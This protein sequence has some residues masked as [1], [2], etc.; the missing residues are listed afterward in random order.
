MTVSKLP[1][2]SSKLPRYTSP[3]SFERLGVY[4]QYFVQFLCVFTFFVLCQEAVIGVDAANSQSCV[5]NYDANTD[6]FPTKSNLAYGVAYYTLK[7]FN[8]HKVITT[9][10][11]TYVLYQCG[12]PMP[13]R[14]SFPVNHT[15]F[16]AVPLTNVGTSDTTSAAFIHALG[17]IDTVKVVDAGGYSSVPCVQKGLNTG[18]IEVEGSTNRVVQATFGNSPGDLYYLEADVIRRSE[19]LK[20]F[21]AFYNLEDVANDVFTRSVSNFN[22]IK[23]ASKSVLKPVLVFVG[24]YM[25]KFSRNHSGYKPQLISDAGATLAPL[26]ASYNTTDQLIEDFIKY[27]VSVVIDETFYFGGAPSNDEV[28][29][30]FGVNASTVNTYP[31][32]KRIFRE[33]KTVSQSYG[34]NWFDD[35]QVY[36]DQILADFVNVVD[37][38]QPYPGYDRRW[39]RDIYNNQSI[40]VVTGERCNPN[41]QNFTITQPVRSTTGEAAAVQTGVVM[42]ML[43]VIVSLMI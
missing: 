14:A 37:P 4:R 36:A 13:D 6:Y 5:S 21:G 20:Y 34:L 18:E 3:I 25:G 40:Y 2:Q 30:L 7:Y 27:N 10:K 8:N 31:W 15:Y 42:V 19:W 1:S 43:A 11:D 17:K 32:A 23:R 28:L 9:G 26:A 41:P 16:F 24:Y 39:L 12:T 35:S 38:Q 22:N 29:T 33:D